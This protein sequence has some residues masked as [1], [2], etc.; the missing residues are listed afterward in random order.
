VQRLLALTHARPNPEMDDDGPQWGTEV[1]V[2]QT[3]GTV[4]QQHIANMVSRDGSC[5]MSR[6][7]LK[8]KFDDCS[9]R[10]LPAARAGKLFDLLLALESQ[11]DLKALFACF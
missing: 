5:P 8:L 4:H 1:I 3:D 6:E 10:C 2:T 9:Q 7:E 11:A